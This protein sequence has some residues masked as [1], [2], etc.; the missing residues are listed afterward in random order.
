M[1]AMDVKPGTPAQNAEAFEAMFGQSGVG[2]PVDNPKAHDL[3]D[4]IVLVSGDLLSA[5]HARSLME[6]RSEETTPWW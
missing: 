3:G 6:L 2:D 5:Q 4:H 1:R